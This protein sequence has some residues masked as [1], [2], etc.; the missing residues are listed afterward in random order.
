MRMWR[1]SWIRRGG[2]VVPVVA[3]PL[4]VI[5]VDPASAGIAVGLALVLLIAG[6]IVSLARSLDDWEA[7]AR[8]GTATLAR[9]QAAQDDMRRAHGEFLARMTHELRTPLNAVVG[10]AQLLAA[11]D[12]TTDQAEN[13][14]HILTAGWHL[15][16]L[17]HDGLDVARVDAGR[18]ELT[19]G[20]LRVAEVVQAASDLVRPQASA[21]GVT[22]ELP[23]DLLA[24]SSLVLA[25]RQRLV[26]VLLNLLANAVKYN[27]PAGHITVSSEASGGTVTISVTDTGAGL[28]PADVDRLF[29]PF[30]R[31]GAHP[32][33]EG[34]GLGLTLS[35]QL[36]QQMGGSLTAFSIEG[37]GST[38]TIELPDGHTPRSFEATTERGAARPSA[39]VAS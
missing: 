13:V 17:V 37:T 5:F 20:P 6:G 25:D 21:Q 10:F 36:A 34:T 30:E 26:Q 31:L 32:D 7:A 23:P 8:E 9:M 39:A 1:H 24:D 15:Q 12:L 18:L 14:A 4:L 19:L 11:D 29:V 27:R 38:F 3:I 22:L 16:Q 35:R 33:I 2:W 28:A